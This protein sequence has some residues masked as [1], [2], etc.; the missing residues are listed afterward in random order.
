MF[1]WRR[2][3]YDELKWDRLNPRLKKSTNELII[4]QFA[5]SLEQ[6]SLWSGSLLDGSAAQPSLHIRRWTVGPSDT[7]LVCYAF[8]LTG[9]NWCCVYYWPGVWCRTFQS[10]FSRPRICHF[11]STSF[12][13]TEFITK[14]RSEWINF[15]LTHSNRILLKCLSCLCW[16]LLPLMHCVH[17]CKE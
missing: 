13:L 10:S 7:V 15:S 2:F 1:E 5:L 6:Q 9:P 11:G 16:H 12:M 3:E 14:L 8:I 17:Y 4:L